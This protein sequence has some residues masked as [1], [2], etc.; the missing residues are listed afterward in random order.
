M[1]E[2]INIYSSILHALFKFFIYF[3]SALDL[4]CFAEAW[5]S[6]F[7]GFLLVMAHRL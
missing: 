2:N 4:P 5:A 1:L 3:L 6:R 7:I